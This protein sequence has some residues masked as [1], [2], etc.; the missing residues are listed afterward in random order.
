MFFTNKYFIWLT[1]LRY[2]SPRP[3]SA[4]LSI[5]NGTKR[6]TS[7]HQLHVESSVATRAYHGVTVKNF[8]YSLKGL[9]TVS[10]EVIKLVSLLA[11]DTGILEKLG[12]M[13]R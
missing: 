12:P 6:L 2:I 5:I 4:L 13:L 3:P 1:P 10:Y 8:Y 11:A 7:T 9:A